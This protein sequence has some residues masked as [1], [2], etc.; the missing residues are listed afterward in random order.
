MF[1]CFRIWGYLGT[2]RPTVPIPSRI[3]AGRT[4]GLIKRVALDESGD[5]DAAVAGMSAAARAQLFGGRI[6]PHC[7]IRVSQNIGTYP[8]IVPYPTTPTLIILPPRE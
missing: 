8:Y 7:D 1:V 3:P 5:V 4:S 6:A 2:P